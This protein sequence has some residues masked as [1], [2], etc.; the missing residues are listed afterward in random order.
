MFLTCLLKKRELRH[1]RG[2][3]ASQVGSQ[4]CA[5]R[6]ARNQALRILGGER[7]RPLRS[8]AMNNFLVKSARLIP[9]KKTS[10]GSL[11]PKNLSILGPTVL[12][13]A[14]NSLDFCRESASFAQHPIALATERRRLHRKSWKG[15]RPLAALLPCLSKAVPLRSWQG[16]SITS[17][18]PRRTTIIKNKVLSP[19]YLGFRLPQFSLR[20]RTSLDTPEMQGWCTNRWEHGHE[21]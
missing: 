7:G 3:A 5:L 6:T 19:T 14:W 11:P 2:C 10:R 16:W 8:W 13:K 12:L 21:R 9:T 18:N 15:M 1:L 4:I 20:F 17:L